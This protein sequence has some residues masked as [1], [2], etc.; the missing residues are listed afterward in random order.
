MALLLLTPD[1]CDTLLTDPLRSTS[2]LSGATA[3]C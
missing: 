2:T 3:L 1:V